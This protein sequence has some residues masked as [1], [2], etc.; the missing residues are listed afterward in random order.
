MKLNIFIT[1][2]NE[3]CS[4]IGGII[5][6]LEGRF[7][8]SH[9]LL[10]KICH[11]GFR[12]F[13]LPK[14][15]AVGAMPR[16]CRTPGNKAQRRPP[17]QLTFHFFIFNKSSWRLMCQL[18]SMR[19]S[20]YV[21]WGIAFCCRMK[22]RGMDETYMQSSPESSSSWCG[23]STDRTTMHSEWPPFPLLP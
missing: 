23:V 15:L 5:T 20:M 22:V 21:P 10:A 3:S 9:C 6:P 7:A 13:A 11:P 19:L 8:S 12:F 4:A 16:A 17:T 1:V 2:Y 18:S 14:I